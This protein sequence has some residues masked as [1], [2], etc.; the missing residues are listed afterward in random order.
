MYSKLI[1]FSAVWTLVGVGRIFSQSG[2]SY[3]DQFLGI[4]LIGLNSEIKLILDL[5]HTIA[6]WNLFLISSSK[7]LSI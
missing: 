3:S 6:L 4:Q 2:I 7:N 5:S 1:Q